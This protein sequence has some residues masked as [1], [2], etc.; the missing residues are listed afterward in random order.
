[1]LLPIYSNFRNYWKSY[2]SDTHLFSDLINRNLMFLRNYLDLGF[3]SVFLLLISVG[4]YKLYKENG[5]LFLI[6]FIPF[7]ILNIGSLFSLYPLGA[8]RTD[9]I[10]FPLISFSIIYFFEIVNFDK[11]KPLIFFGLIVVLITTNINL[12]EREDNS[13][14]IFN[15]ISLTEYDKVYISYYSIPQFVIYNKNFGLLD[16]QLNK[17]NYKSTDERIEFLANGFTD[18]DRCQVKTNLSNLD[19]KSN[20]QKIAILGFDSKTQGLLSFTN[21]LDKSIYKVKVQKFGTQEYIIEI[22]LK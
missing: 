20:G 21:L 15:S 11:V 8:G 14:E 13:K 7:V 2:Y 3:L 18:E 19:I 17:C 9:I 10:I 5:E 16:S 4:A 12:I 1:M 6:T 22:D